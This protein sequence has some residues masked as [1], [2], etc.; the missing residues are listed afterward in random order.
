MRTFKADVTQFK[1]PNGRQVQ[2]TTQLP[3]SVK[4]YYEGMECNGCRLEAEVLSTGLVSVTISGKDEDL[5]IRIVKN[6]PDVQK[7][8]CEMLEAQLWLKSKRD[9]QK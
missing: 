9:L 4:V 6:G 3:I 2:Q 8:Y 5:D 7:A 1:Q